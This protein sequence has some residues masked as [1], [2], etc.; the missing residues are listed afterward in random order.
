MSND[1]FIGGN[2]AAGFEYLYH[3]II[4][5]GH[6]FVNCYLEPCS[7][8]YQSTNQHSIKS[9]ISRKLRIDFANY[10]MSDSHL[11]SEKISERLAMLNPSTMC[12][13]LRT[14]DDNHTLDLLTTA[15]DE[16]NGTNEDHVYGLI[17]S[18]NLRKRDGSEVS[19]EY[20]VE[21]FTQDFRIT[22]AQAT[23][24]LDK[25][26]RSLGYGIIPI[27]LRLYEL[28]KTIDFNLQELIA[29]INNIIS[30]SPEAY[31]EHRESTLFANFI[32]IG[33]TCFLLG[34]GIS[35]VQELVPSKKG[36]PELFL[37]NLS[38][39][40]WNMVKLK[41]NGVNNFFPLG[42]TSATK[43]SIFNKLRELN[44]HGIIGI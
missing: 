13:F 41:I 38:N 19:Y 24:E 2:K 3:H 25:T 33:A 18:N 6:C 1:L 43:Q 36:T 40:H 34:T 8:S 21:L 16:Y 32:N 44:A 29:M 4:G 31:F 27:T 5:D 14:I 10:L 7:A 15:F 35:T 20:L 42:V 12:F 11:S 17:L 30:P 37:V 39:V 9:R 28:T 26:G 22:T 23:H